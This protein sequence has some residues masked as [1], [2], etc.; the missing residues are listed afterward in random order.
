MVGGPGADCGVLVRAEVVQHHAQLLLG[1]ALSQGLERAEERADIERL[2]VV[3]PE[4]ADVLSTIICRFSGAGGTVPLI[5]ACDY[6]ELVWMDPAPLVCQHRV[7]A[8][9]HRIGRE[10]ISTLL[11]QA[12]TRTGLVDA[13]GTPLHC[14]PHDFRRI[15][16]TDAI[17]NGLP[18]H[19]AQVIAG[20][21]DI[22]VTIG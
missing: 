12:L 3:G 2:L 1:P 11:D 6:H 7:G 22:S 8:G 4:L 21:Q 13:D 17:M 20:H 18:P 15:F 9:P 19:I 16:I 10:R 5:R 14:T